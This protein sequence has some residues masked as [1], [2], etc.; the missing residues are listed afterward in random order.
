M[1]DKRTRDKLFLKTFLKGKGEVTQE[2]LEY[3]RRHPD[4]IDEITAPVNVH[5]LFLLYGA[6]SGILLVVLSKVLK[7]SSVLY[8]ARDY[9]QEFLVDIVFEIG[10]ALIGAG[11]TA[12]LL[13]ILL[14]TQQENAERWRTEIRTRIREADNPGKSAQIG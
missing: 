7:F 12:Y 2:E 5:K 8:F 11:V 1:Q 9:L 10:I 6:L 13:G 4:E 3:F 14:N